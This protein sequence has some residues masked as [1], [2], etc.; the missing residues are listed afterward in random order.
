VNGIPTGT[1]Y[2]L[3]FGDE[4][5]ETVVELRREEVYSKFVEKLWRAVCVRLVMQ[6]ATT[7]KSG[8]QVSVGDAVVRDECVILKKHKWLGSDERVRCGWRQVQ[9]WTADGSFVIGAT[10]DKKTYA[11][12]SYIHVPN[13]HVVEHLIRLGFEKGV[14]NLSDVLQDE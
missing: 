5:S 4:D 11:A 14:D 8:S 10:D 7:L 2:T 3:A 6:L 1:T 12:L 13:V 9:V